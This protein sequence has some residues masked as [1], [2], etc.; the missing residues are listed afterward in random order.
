MHSSRFTL[1]WIGS[2]VAT[3]AFTSVIHKSRQQ[4]AARA[5]VQHLFLAAERDSS[6]SSASSTTT[7]A[8]TDTTGTTDTTST[9]R[10]P[11][12]FDEMVRATSSAMSD[13]Y[14]KGITRQILRILLPRDPT[15]QDLGIMFEGDADLSTNNLL[16]YPVDE[17]WQGGIMQLYRAAAPTCQAILRRFSRNEGGIPPRLIEDRSI[18]ES[19]VDGIG[20]WM[21]QNASPAED[22]SCFVQPTQETMDAMESISSQAGTRLVCLL[23]PQWRN[24][25]DALDTASQESGFLGS[26]AS[27][28]GG[29]GNALKRLDI[30]GYKNVFTV[31]GYVCKGGNIRLVKRFDSDWAVF[32]ENDSATD[33]IQV[34]TSQNRPT[35][36]D[37]DKMLDN[38]GISVKYARDIGL[39]PKFERKE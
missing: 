5:R 9:L 8:S 3:S 14:Q 35:Y 15:S 26:L 30:L 34:G 6:T 18:D 23:N 37:C 31:E 1:A 29:K 32:A 22:V 13:A 20:L 11:V 28:L 25:N 16:L 39:A 36:Q 2:M 27:F 7:T 17:S 10:V 19:G 12:S 21:S 38:M 24:V 33:Y 4:S